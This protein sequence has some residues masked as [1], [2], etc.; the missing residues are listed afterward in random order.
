[1]GNQDMQL[2]DWINIGIILA[3][4]AITYI[5]YN[6]K[7]WSQSMID[8]NWKLPLAYLILF[9]L[10]HYTL[11]KLGAYGSEI[12]K[13]HDVFKDPQSTSIMIGAAI[14][15]AFA[16]LGLLYANRRYKLASEQISLQTTSM[17]QQRFYDAVKLL[18]DERE[19]LQLGAL[20]AIRQICTKQNSP[21]FEE[22]RQILRNFLRANTNQN[23]PR[24]LA[25]LAD[26]LIP[27][28]MIANL[29][30]NTLTD[31]I[32]AQHH[33]KREFEDREQIQNFALVNLRVDR[34]TKL[35]SIKFSNCN[36]RYS[37]FCEAQLDDVVFMPGDRTSSYPDGSPAPDLSY[38]DFTATKFNECIFINVAISG[39]TFAVSSGL[40]EK[41]LQSCFYSNLS[42]PNGLPDGILLRFPYSDETRQACTSDE[43]DQFFARN[44]HFTRHILREGNREVEIV[45]IDHSKAV[46]ADNPLETLRTIMG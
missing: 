1:M 27:I 39:A 34:L 41:S 31:I 3:P 45:K 26:S 12:N 25:S 20:T 42:P 46:N 15:P 16:I 7:K 2:E 32:H 9:L 29:A 21:Y 5:P 6:T 28:S 14:A 43:L 33:Q 37:I 24:G 19:F 18:G 40:F 30:F 13:W 4:I 11:I 44:P 23:A 17:D 36:L 38:A 10:A 35:K 8:S 22:V